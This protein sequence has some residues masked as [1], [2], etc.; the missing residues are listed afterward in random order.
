MS[1]GKKLRFG[2]NRD[3][4]IGDGYYAERDG[5]E[6]SCSSSDRESR[7]KALCR[8]AM[9]TAEREREREREIYRKRANDGVSFFSVYLI[10][11]CCNIIFL[12]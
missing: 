9:D 5:D 8:N 3:A 4:I 12:N 6:A 10:S 11:F 1:G 2:S 7:I